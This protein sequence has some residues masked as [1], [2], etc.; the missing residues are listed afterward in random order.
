[1][2]QDTP[3]NR[4][5]IAELSD[6]EIDALLVGIAERRLAPVKAYEEAALIAAGVRSERLKADLEKQL[7]MFSKDLVTMDKKLDTMTKRALKIRAIRLEI[8]G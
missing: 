5:S 6:D 2:K 4:A 7:E 3:I 1:M 8:D